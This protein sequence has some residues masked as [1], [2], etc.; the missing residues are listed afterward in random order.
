MAIDLTP[1]RKSISER[2]GVSYPRLALEHILARRLGAELAGE[3]LDELKAAEQRYNRA[4]RVESLRRRYWGR[5]G[6][7]GASSR[8]AAADA[9]N[10]LILANA[11]AFIS[12]EWSPPPTLW[13]K[14]GT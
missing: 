3:I 2:Y 10:R 13:T 1:G 6:S 8:Q 7:P 9:R 11:E 14:R 5:T 4:A 12:G